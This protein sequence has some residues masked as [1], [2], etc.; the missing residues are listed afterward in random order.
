MKIRRIES[1][2]VWAVESTVMLS[3]APGRS[4]IVSVTTIRSIFELLVGQALVGGAAEDAVGGAGDHPGGALLEHRLGGGAERAGRVDHVVDE[5]RGLALDVADHVADLGD[6]LGGPLLLHDGP[7]DADLAGE[8][9]RDLDPAGVG[10][11]DH[12]L[13][14]RGAGR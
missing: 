2:S 3:G 10:A 7:V 5:D 14:G 9:A 12:E 13:V 11:D 4:G 8:V 6:L 1:A